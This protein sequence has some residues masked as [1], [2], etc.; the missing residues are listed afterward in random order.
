MKNL[1]I[2][3]VMC[4]IKKFGELDGLGCIFEESYFYK[5]EIQ[6]LF[7]R[8]QNQ[9]WFILQGCKT[10]LTKKNIIYNLK[11]FFLLP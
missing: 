4:H 1:I 7:Y 2:Y 9:K 8:G 6:F 11:H 10:L 3:T 5:D